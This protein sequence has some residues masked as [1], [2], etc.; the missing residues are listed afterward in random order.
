METSGRLHSGP[1]LQAKMRKKHGDNADLLLTIVFCISSNK[2]AGAER[3]EDHPRLCADAAVV[4][5][6]EKLR[7]EVLRL[8][9]E[10]TRIR[11]ALHHLQVSILVLWAEIHHYFRGVWANDKRLVYKTHGCVLCFVQ[12]SPVKVAE[13][14]LEKVH[15][16]GEGQVCLGL[17]WCN[18]V[19]SKEQT[20]QRE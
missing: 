19:S 20:R 11:Q 13:N 9:Q 3:R 8:L 2:D 15:A 16:F 7:L 12:F 6:A 4:R 5:H 14:D 18:N 10:R 1:V 17:I